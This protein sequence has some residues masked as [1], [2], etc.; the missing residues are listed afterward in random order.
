V[1]KHDLDITV[2]RV[3]T[4]HRLAA[5]AMEIFV[6]LRPIASVHPGVIAKEGCWCWTLSAG[7]R[8][9]AA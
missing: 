4:R 1:A 5:V 8:G 3:R 9:T 2:V 7:G 6:L